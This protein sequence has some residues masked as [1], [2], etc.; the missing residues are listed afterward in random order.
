MTSRGPDQE[1]PP[2]IADA[3][4]PETRGRRTVTG[5]PHEAARLEERTGQPASASQ[6]V[7]VIRRVTTYGSIL[8]LGRRSS[9]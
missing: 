6:Q 8:A 4:G 5:E 9:M 1:S 3:P 7:L 2:K